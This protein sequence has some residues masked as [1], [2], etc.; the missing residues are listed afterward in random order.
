MKAFLTHAFEN[1]KTTASGILSFLMITG[2]F[3]SGYFALNQSPTALKISG[4]ATFVSSLAKVYIGA[5][6]T[7][8]G[9]TP[10]VLPGSP[11]VQMAASH[12]TP[13]NPAATP[14]VPAVKVG[15]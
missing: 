7:D 12:E 4:I 11:V 9:K 13:D 15:K 8:A 5:L 6:L 2:T 1:W 3:V 14:V 10:V